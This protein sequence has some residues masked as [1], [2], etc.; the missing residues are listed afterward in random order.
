M[1]YIIARYCY[2]L[3]VFK[4]TLER[5]PTTI[6]KVVSNK[7]FALRSTEVWV[8]GLPGTFEDTVSKDATVEFRCTDNDFMRAVG[9]CKDKYIR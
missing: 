3:I 7:S 8:D 1:L 4:Y 6:Y 5:L 2:P 9:A